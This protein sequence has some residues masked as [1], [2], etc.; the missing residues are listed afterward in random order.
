MGTDK[1][2]YFL[3]VIV[4]PLTREMRALATQFPPHFPLPM[5]LTAGSSAKLEW[6]SEL[7]VNAMGY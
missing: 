7:A 2:Y 5:A 1:M 6:R 4:K 3:G